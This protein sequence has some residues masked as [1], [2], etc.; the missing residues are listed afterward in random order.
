MAKAASHSI[1]CWVVRPSA[2]F[3]RVLLL[4]VAPSGDVALG[5]WQPITGGVES[6][7]TSVRAC[8]VHQEKP[9]AS[10]G[11]DSRPGKG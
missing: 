1:G 3:W 9:G 6:G 10:S 5:F 11:W 4:H 2:G 7:E 8:L